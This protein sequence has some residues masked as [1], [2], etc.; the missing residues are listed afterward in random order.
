MAR[1]VVCP[2]CGFGHYPSEDEPRKTH[3][4]EN[5]VRSP[6]R[7]AA[8]GALPMLPAPQPTH[9]EAPAGMPSMDTHVKIPLKQAMIF[10]WL[11]FP[12]GFIVGAVAVGTLALVIDVTP[13]NVNFT[14]WGM[15]TISTAGGIVGGVIAFCQAAKVRWPER[16][17]AYDALLWAEEL[18]ELDLNRDEEIGEPEPQTIKVE[19]V[20]PN[21]VPRAFADLPI[22]LPRF[23][24]LARLVIVTGA[25]F[26]QP[27]AGQAGISRDEFNALRDVMV[28]R[29]YA[30][31]NHGK[32]RRQGVSLNLSGKSLLKAVLSPAVSGAGESLKSVGGTN[33]RTPTK[34]SG[35][36]VRYEE[37][38]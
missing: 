12:K 38:E 37:I 1:R 32:E 21:G 4:F 26:S 14:G 20:Q 29:G 23:R 31:W 9:R 15:L 8:A 18:T 25:G 35:L 34:E 28:E 30:R 13:A 22:D 16:L 6:F 3:T 36:I 5:R 24:E 2:N 17:G 11:D 33:E 27:T 7:N 10:G 19:M